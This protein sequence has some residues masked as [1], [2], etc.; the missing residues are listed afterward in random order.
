MFSGQLGMLDIERARMRLF[1]R[2]ADLWEKIDQHLGLDLK[3]PRQF[4]DA[5]LIGI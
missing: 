2:D 5:N 1:L 4:V 3:L